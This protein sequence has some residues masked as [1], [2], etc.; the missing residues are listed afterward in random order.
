MD[1]LTDLMSE[2]IDPL[3]SISLTRSVIAFPIP[4]LSRLRLN[5]SRKASIMVIFGVAAIVI[6]VATVCVA[7]MAI[8]TSGRRLNPSWLVVWGMVESPVGGCPG[9]FWLECV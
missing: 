1:V 4:I 7:E 3:A 6:C 8:R 5:R 2:S 9:I